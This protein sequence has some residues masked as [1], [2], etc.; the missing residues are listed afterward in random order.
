[1][2]LTSMESFPELFTSV[3][4]TPGGR[5][6]VK[7]A[8]LPKAV[9]VYLISVNVPGRRPN[10]LILIA[11]LEPGAEMP[12]VALIAGAVGFPGSAPKVKLSVLFPSTK[13]F[14][15]KETPGRIFAAKV[16]L[17]LTTMSPAG[18]GKDPDVTIFSV[19][20]ATIVVPV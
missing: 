5:F 11:M 2:R 15:G 1:M 10:A 3:P 19:P 16:A 9:P 12:P 8:T 6:R 17:L 20:P 13:L 18:D 14:A 7:L 4:K